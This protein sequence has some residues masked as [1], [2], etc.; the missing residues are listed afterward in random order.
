MDQFIKTPGSILL[1]TTMI[2]V[3]LDIPTATLIAIYSAEYFGLSQLHQLR[4]RV[5]RSDI[6]SECYV[7]SQKDDVERLEILTKTD[8]GFKLAEYDLIERGP[9]D[10]LGKEQSGYLKFSFLD[11]VDDYKILI[12]AFKNVE[13]LMAQKDFKTNSKYRYLNK[14]IKNT[15]KIWYNYTYERRDTYD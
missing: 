9:G 1:A 7:I 10:F 8:D 6:A 15:L 13:Y 14:H 3:G 2:E 5:G 4:G 12:E 11:L